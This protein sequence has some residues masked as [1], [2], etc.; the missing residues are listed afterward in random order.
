MAR[1]CVNVRCGRKVWYIESSW[2][3]VDDVEVGEDEKEDVRDMQVRKN[4]WNQRRKEM[5]L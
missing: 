4:R 2:E 5:P 3:F 1:D